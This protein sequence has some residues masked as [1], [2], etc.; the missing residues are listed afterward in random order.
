MRSNL[1][2]IIV[3]LLFSCQKPTNE[4]ITTNDPPISLFRDSIILTPPVLVQFS[5][6]TAGDYVNFL[7]DFGDGGFSFLANPSN[8]YSNFGIY[9]VRLLQR[10]AAGIGDTTIKQ[11]DTRILGSNQPSST[12][13]FNYFVSIIPPIQVNFTNQ[14]TNSNSYLWEFG[15]GTTSTSN[16]DTLSHIY[17][18]NGTYIV[19]LISTGIGGVDSSFKI[20][21]L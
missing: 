14:S 20:L 3:V 12:T 6:P 7:W 2:L 17:S 15:D 9:A 1:F 13:S 10:N 16:A 8:S 21:D 4:N 5:N 11:I 19:K 18:S